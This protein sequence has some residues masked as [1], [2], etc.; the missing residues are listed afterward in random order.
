[1]AETSQWFVLLKTFAALAAVLALIV[2]LSWAAKKYLRPELW[3]KTGL[4][5]MKVSQIFPIE[6]KKRLLVVEIDD[7]KLLLG[8]AETN[9][10]FLCDLSSDVKNQT[11]GVSKENAHVAE[12]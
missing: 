10:S 7:R 3:T 5:A 12:L 11:V 4:K 1:M 6:N 8:V 9:I 2:T